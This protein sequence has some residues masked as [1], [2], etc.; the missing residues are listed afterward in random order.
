M[1]KLNGRSWSTRIVLRTRKRFKCR[2]DIFQ[3]RV[4]AILGQGAHGKAEVNI[5]LKE[6]KAFGFDSVE[7]KF[8][9]FV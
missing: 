6:A 9:N 2:T 7:G 1:H 3:K 4:R 8:R 5:L